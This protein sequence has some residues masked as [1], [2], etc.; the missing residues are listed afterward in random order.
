MRI[1]ISGYYGFGNTGDEA[2]LAVIVQ[3][4]RQHYPDA[5]IC[6]L[7]AEP[8]ETARDYG[9]E[10][11][12]RWK[13]STVWYH[14]RRAD[15]FIQGGGGLLQDTTSARSSLYYLGLLHMARISR[16]PFMIFGQGI[17]PLESSFIRGLTVRNLRRARAVTVRDEASAR[18]LSEWGL[19]RPE[20]H[21]TADPG[22]LLEAAPQ[23]RCRQLLAA[24][25]I[26]PDVP[27]IAIALRRWPGLADFLPHLVAL[28]RQRE[29]RLLL[30]PFQFEQDLPLAL[31]LSR[32]LPGRVHLPDGPLRPRETVGIIGGA[33]AVVAMRLHAMIF[34][35]GQTVP[36]VG[37]S[38]DPKV[39]A[40]CARSGQPLLHLAEASRRRLEEA[41]EEA[42]SATGSP[43]GS[44]R[45]EALQDAAQRNFDILME[46]L[47]GRME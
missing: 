38:Y 34:A 27:Y 37:L 20:V 22:L 3:R 2:V 31:E 15:F 18:M 5:E 43:E 32:A 25:D 1:L 7:S 17:G 11:A 28:L 35:A 24:L 13:T 8:E 45:L 9:V 47:D 41:L 26:E 10:A 42:A 44:R 30:L 14:M 23:E 40:F 4:L 12:D 29:E 39:D 21:V 6:V 33:A 36:A 19:A 16:T 46:V